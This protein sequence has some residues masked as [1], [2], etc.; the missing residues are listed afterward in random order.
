MKQANEQLEADVTI[1]GCGIAGLWSAKELIDQ[2]ARVTLVEKS[3]TIADGATTRNEGWLHAGT[4]HA[5]AVEDEA[6]A[7]QITERT[8]YGHDQILQFA[9]ESI[10][11][12]KTVALTSTDTITADAIKRWDKAG[13]EH[14]EIRPGTLADADQLNLERVHAAF[15]VKDKSVNSVT[16]CQKLARY[17]IQNGGQIFTDTVFT[18]ES[19]TTA[20]LQVAGTGSYHVRSDKFLLTA[21]TGIKDLMHH[22]TGVEPLVRYF[23][24]HLLVTPRLTRDNYFYLDVGEAGIMNHGDASIVGIN[25]DGIMLPEPTYDVV[26]EKEQLI[27]NALK[28]MLPGASRYQTAAQ[29]MTVACCKPDLYAAPT[30]TQNLNVQVFEPSPNYVCALPGKMTEAPYLG[31][32]AALF[33]LGHS[34]ANHTFVAREANNEQVIPD[35]TCRPVDRWMAQT[36]FA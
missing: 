20:W 29:I 30:D 5:L 11:H 10:D 2:G 19:D 15:N 18:P 34:N 27:Y 1:V 31:R 32:A 7:L 12:S 33:V 6:N 8:I 35:V 13:V 22:L 36:H 9:P 4:Y 14:Q 21:G 28:R 3:P 16:L 24:A 23:Q 25:R 26:P 17:V